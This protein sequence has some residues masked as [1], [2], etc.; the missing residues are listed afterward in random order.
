[1]E[2]ILVRGPSGSGKTTFAE[3]LGGTHIETDEYWLRPDGEYDFN[4]KLLKQAHEWCREEV[5]IAMYDGEVDVIVSNTFTQFWEMKPY[6][7]LAKK[8]D[9]EVVVYRMTKQYGNTHGVPEDVVR[10]QTE[11]ME[12]YEGEI[13]AW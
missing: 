6:L 2:L 1:M 8:F 10:K 9:Y 5:A 13:L 12:D 11:R 4:Y 3:E 7:E